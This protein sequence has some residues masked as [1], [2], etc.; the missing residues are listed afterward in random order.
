[1]NSLLKAWATRYYYTG[2]G[3]EANDDAIRSLE[4]RA[5]SVEAQYQKAFVKIGRAHV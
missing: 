5:D 1:M 4:E 3:K 2:L